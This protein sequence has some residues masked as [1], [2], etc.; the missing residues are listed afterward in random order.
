MSFFLFKLDTKH[1]IIFALMIYAIYTVHNEFRNSTD[2]RD[3]RK[4]VFRVLADVKLQP[5]Q[6]K[7]LWEVLAW[8][9]GPLREGPSGVS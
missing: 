5:T 9:L 3:F 4:C 1:S 6:S 7:I 2:H 8:R